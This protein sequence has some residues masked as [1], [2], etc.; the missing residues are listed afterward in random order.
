MM[1]HENKIVI[2]W[3]YCYS[4]DLPN[5]N[6][7]WTRLQLGSKFELSLVVSLIGLAP[8]A[9]EHSL[10]SICS[11]LFKMDMNGGKS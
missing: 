5:L 9:H 1:L 2:S 7:V 8:F 4:K 10:L 3:A 11:I 6:L